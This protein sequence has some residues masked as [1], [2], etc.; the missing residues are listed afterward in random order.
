[1][2]VILGDD[3]MRE[4]VGGLGVRISAAVEPEP[5][6]DEPVRRDGRRQRPGAA[7]LDREGEAITAAMRRSGGVV[8]RAARELGISRQTLYRRLDSL[9]IPRLR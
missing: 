7:A 8:A 9:A 3:G 1:V 4:V 2:P 5:A 6:A